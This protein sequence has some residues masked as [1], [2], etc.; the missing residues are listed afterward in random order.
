MAKKADLHVHSIYSHDAVSKPETILQ[1][2]A[3][4]GIDII[5]VTDHDSR[6]WKEF[7]EAA[8]RYPVQVVYGQEIRLWN[9]KFPA[10]DLL[11]LFLEKPIVGTTAAE[12]IAETAAQGGIVSLAHPFCGRRGDFRAY[13]LIDDWSRLAIEV[14]N[15]RTYK[16]RDNEMAELLAQRLDLPITAGS[17]AH[18]PFEIGSVYL[19]FDGSTIKDLKNAILHRRVRAVGEPAS[20]VFSILSAF[21]RLGIGL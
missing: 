19:E 14:R 21:G 8:R 9:G 13:D 5:A 20:P 1:S 18:T 10:G 17:D 7:R 6:S 2:A 11:A 15:G 3:D 16:S 12:I 4:R